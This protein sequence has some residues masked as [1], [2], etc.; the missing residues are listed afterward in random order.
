[1][2]TQVHSSLCI[3]KYPPGHLQSAHWPR[4]FQYLF[5]HHT[6]KPAEESPVRRT[7]GLGKFRRDIEMKGILRWKREIEYGPRPE[8]QK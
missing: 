8:T 2:E 6:A 5:G 1:M 4:W 3:V 7:R